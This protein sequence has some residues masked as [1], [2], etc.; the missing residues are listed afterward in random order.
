MSDEKSAI[1][2][3]RVLSYLKR[4]SGK[5]PKPSEAETKAAVAGLELINAMFPGIADDPA[6]AVERLA[7][8]ARK[9]NPPPISSPLPSGSLNR[10]K[11]EQSLQKMSNNS[12]M[13]HDDAMAVI[14]KMGG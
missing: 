6:I 12:K 10:F 7:D 2:A 1:L 5:G 4:K 3:S 13:L 9:G 8:L 14:R 11:A